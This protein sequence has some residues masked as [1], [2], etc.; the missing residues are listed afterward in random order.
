[1]YF[2]LLWVLLGTE[3][4]LEMQPEGKFSLHSYCKYET[5]FPVQREGKSNLLSCKNQFSF[6]FPS[7]GQLTRNVGTSVCDIH[8]IISRSK[9]NIL[10]TAAAIFVVSAVYL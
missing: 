6:G 4:F 5:F 9:G 10:G 8:V 2:A 7:E 3:I 1:M